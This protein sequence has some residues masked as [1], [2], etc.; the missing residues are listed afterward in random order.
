MERSQNFT[1]W[2][3][4]TT[5]D[6]IHEEQ[7]HTAHAQHVAAVK[8]HEDQEANKRH[9]KGGWKKNELSRACCQH[10]TKD[11]VSKTGCQKVWQNEP[12]SAVVGVK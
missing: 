11:E 7:Q 10:Q 2:P 3:A 8:Y 4:R 1:P 9:H 6:S 5:Y 12:E